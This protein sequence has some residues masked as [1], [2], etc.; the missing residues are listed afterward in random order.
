MCSRRGRTLG[1]LPIRVSSACRVA[2]RICWLPLPLPKRAA[3]TSALVLP[4]GTF[5]CA[6]SG[7]TKKQC[8]QLRGAALKAIWGTKRGRRCP[9]IVLTLFAQGH[10]VDPYQVAV[11]QSMTTFR[12]MMLRRPDLLTLFES[13]W[14]SHRQT[15][16]LATGPVSHLRAAV[17]RLGW[18]WP[19]PWTFLTEEGCE[20]QPLQMPQGE[21]EHVLRES[22]RKAEWR[23]AAARRS[24]MSGIEHG[25]DRDATLA[26]LSGNHLVPFEQGILRGILAGAI[27]TQDR[28]QRSGRVASSVCEHCNTGEMEDHSHMW[29]RCPAW[30]GA[31]QQ[32]WQPAFS[33]AA[34]W[35]PCLSICGIVPDNFNCAD[36]RA[37]PVVDFTGADSERDAA[38]QPRLT[39]EVETA[40]EGRVVVYTD[41][42]A[43]DNQRRNLRRAGLG[44]Y[45]GKDHAWNVSE[46][47]L[48]PV[49]TNNRAE[50]AAVIRTL[51]IDKRPLDIRTDS[52]YVFDGVAVNMVVWENSNWKRNGR[53]VSHKDLWQ[54]LSKLLSERQPGQVTVKKIKGHATAKDVIAGL[55]STQ[56]RCGNHA[57]DT[58]AV[59]GARSHAMDPQ[60]R[61]SVLGRTVLA[62]GVQHMMT[63]IVSARNSKLASRLAT[64][65]ISVNSSS[66][67]NSSSSNNSSSSGGSN[68]GRNSSS[69]STT[70]GSLDSSD[71]N[72]RR[73]S[74]DGEVIVVRQRVLI[75]GMRRRRG[76]SAPATPE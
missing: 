75:G 38:Q 39:T 26:L 32:H 68:S 49:Q 19:S 42:A 15:R 3:L 20:V 18:R 74:R 62:Q 63:D 65:T 58:L 59:A 46:A 12:S 76:R 33:S 14:D 73:V 54:R 2:D 60:T 8:Q 30:D 47:L 56:D 29:W 53:E 44:A 66:R 21:W 11:Y 27:W 70:S 17:A 9:E 16:I 23:T 50:L 55:I 52:K 61:K 13:V 51:E 24:D 69:S 41:G 5:G 35:P 31:R 4:R 28:A 6:A 40:C 1:V 72:E 10:R 45:W 67:S 57:A 43:R 37:A 71:S 22:A 36:G 25:I 48:G 34:S 7:I 64:E